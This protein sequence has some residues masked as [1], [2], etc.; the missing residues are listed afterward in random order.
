MGQRDNHHGNGEDRYFV[1]YKWTVPE[2]LVHNKCSIRI[3]YNI[4]STDYEAWNV[5]EESKI[6]NERLSRYPMKKS[7][8]YDLGKDDSAIISGRWVKDVVGETGFENALEV[9]P[10]PKHWDGRIKMSRSDINSDVWRIQTLKEWGWQWVGWRDSGFAGRKVQVSFDVKFA[11]KPNKGHY[12]MKFYGK[13]VNDWVDDA[14]VG[15]WKSVTIDEVMP[16][17]DDGDHVIFIFDG[18]KVDL[19]VRGF[20]ICVIDEFEGR[21]NP[22]HS[23]Q[24]DFGWDAYT[25]RS[26][27][28]EHRNDARL[29]I[30]EDIPMRLRSAYNTDQLGRVFEDRSHKIEFR[31]VPDDVKAE[32]EKGSKLYNINARGKIGNNVEVYPAFEYDFVP[33]RLEA[34]QGDFIHI[35]WSGS[36]TNDRGDDHSQVDENG[37]TVG[38]LQGKDRHNMVM[39]DDFGDVKPSE[40]LEKLGEILGLSSDD[41]MKLAF[42]GVVGGDNESLQSAGAYFDLGIRKLDKKGKAMFMSTVNNRFGVRTQKG[43]VIVN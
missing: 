1:G 15:E 39:I 7:G 43:K 42:D 9:N 34:N 30:F 25:A 23:F 11:K 41:L 28:Y 5:D 16:R 14:K 31:Q 37:N 26:R 18:V 13:L 27:G 2:N 22:F 12:G 17:H 3:R 24:D 4:T 38:W 35:Q 33:S 36:N 10:R 8:C 6:V 40:D 19:E 21:I 20:K 29:Q 32:L